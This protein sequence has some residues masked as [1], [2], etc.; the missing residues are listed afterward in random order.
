[1]IMMGPTD[2]QIALNA[3]PQDEEDRSTH[4]HSDK[5]KHKFD[6][7]FQISNPKS[8]ISNINPIIQDEMKRKAIVNN[9]ETE[10]KSGSPVEGVL[11][12]GIDVKQGLWVPLV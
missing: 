12:A 11:E 6:F 8:E 3:S 5:K 10:K 7:D 4:C 1:M 9:S 2:S